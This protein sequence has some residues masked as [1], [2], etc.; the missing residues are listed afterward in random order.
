MLGNQN[1]I[2]LFIITFLLSISLSVSQY[3]QCP[4]GGVSVTSEGCKYVQGNVTINCPTSKPYLCPDFACVESQGKCSKYIP[5]CPPQKPYKCWNNECRVSFEECPTPVTCAPEFPVLCQSGLCVKTKADCEE[6]KTGDC[7]YYRCFDGTCVNSIE[8]CPTHVFCGKDKIKCWNGAC[9]D[10]VEEC[11]SSQLDNCPKEFPYRCHDGTCGTEFQSCSTISTCPPHLPVKCFDNSCRASTSECPEFQSCGESKVACPD[12]TCALNY[13]ACNTVVTCT[14]DKPFLCYDNTCRVQLDDCPEP[15]KC[16]KTEVVC[17]NGSCMSSRQYCKFFEACDSADNP[18]RCEMNSCTD[19]YSQCSK[20]TKR[21]PIGYVQCDNGDCK[22]SEYLCDK[23]ECPKNKPYFCKEGVC[24]HDKELCDNPVN[25]CPYNAPYK[26]LD[27]TCVKSEE[28]C[29]KSYNCTNPDHKLCPDGSCIDEKEECPL[30]NGCYK[31]RP[32]RCADGSCVNP[33]SSSC[34]P[35]LCPFLLPIKCPN[36]NCVAKSSD[37]SVNLRTDDLIDCG[38]GLIM[39]VDGRCVESSDYCRPNYDCETGYKKCP[40]GSCRVSLNLCPQGVKCPASRPYRC[41][42]QLCVK[43]EEEC[44]HGII[45]PKGYTKCQNNGLC[46]E[47]QEYCEE[48]FVFQSGCAEVGYVK[49]PNGRCAKDLSSCSSM[50]DACPDN[51]APYLCPNGECASDSS[52]CSSGSG[53]G[54][55]KVK[56]PSGGCA[57][58]GK[59]STECTN[60][61]GCPLGKPYRCSN[62][63]CVESSRK[64]NVTTISSYGQLISNVACDE[65]KPYQ[66]NDKSCVTNVNFCKVSEKCPAAQCFNGYCVSDSSACK[67]FDGYCPLSMPVQCPSGSCVDEL[68]KCATSFGE[69]ACVEGEFYCAR[70]NKCLTKKLDCLV[71]L[72]SY[73]EKQDK[74]EKQEENKNQTRRLLENFVDPLKDKDFINTHKK[75]I[76]LKEED[77]QPSDKQSSSSSVEVICYDGTIAKGDEKCPIVPA[78]K[79]G[80]YRCENGGCASTMEICGTDND[81]VCKEGQKK[82]PDG[83]CH[84]DCNEVAFNGCDVGK[85]Q[86]TNGLCVEDRYEC[87]GHSMCPDPIFPYRCITGECRGSPSECETLDRIGRVQNLTYSFNKLNKVEFSFAFDP[88]GRTIGRIEI[89]GNGL[90]FDGNYSKL[91]IEEVSSS[92]LYRSNLY[93]NTA[94]FLF[95]VSNSIVASEGLLNFENCILTPAFKF[96]AGRN[97]KTKIEFRLAGRIK[98]LHNYYEEATTL[99]VEDYCLAKLR[100]FDLDK[101]TIA[102][103]DDQGW[104][105]VERQTTEEQTEFQIKEFGVYAVMLNPL[106][107]KYNWFSDTGDIKAKNFFLENIKSILIVLGIIILLIALIFYIFFRVTRYR[108]KYHENRTKIILLQQQKQEYENM[109]TD[110]FGQTLGDNI[111]GIVY[112]ANPAYTTNDDIKKGGTSLEEEIEKLQIECKNVS[113]QNDRLQKDIA[114]ITEQYK[115]LTAS[116]ENNGK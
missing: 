71:Y 5:I 68:V 64:C 87:I 29:E 66:C 17:P 67:E 2:G 80:Q 81:Y 54:S 60:D 35:V 38:E 77:E 47:S 69:P 95:N 49:C 61:I 99:L 112:K 28:N 42:N 20:K 92:G 46:M 56:C 8:L 105:C 43:N 37:C 39:C 52:K 23:F 15:P 108:E 73:I 93:N 88:N 13:D 86:C 91:Y 32:F 107:K 114:D 104:E 62:G 102:E 96:Y 65:A 103:G 33:E 97:S 51:S 19:N 78:C 16:K 110:I 27:G 84:T 82:C 57:T 45:C 18:I 9:V 4:N 76:T 85:Y 89:P 10:S 26:C 12:G 1:C 72:D 98:F 3:V 63:E 74:Q 34:L 41:S 116:I 55:G 36:G 83:M 59:E 101:D 100:G 109:T 90:S 7:P 79:I 53:C 11:R 50:S 14:S 21:C 40:D 115:T 70:L 44:I 75:L 6:I 48:G 106:R 111:N 94:E 25:G 58:K 30:Q 113:D 22:T 24:V 31:D